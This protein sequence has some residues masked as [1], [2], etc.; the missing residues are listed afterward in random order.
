ML[1]RLVRSG[2]VTMRARL[3]API[4]DLEWTAGALSTALLALREPVAP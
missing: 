4:D 2:P 3:L 1:E